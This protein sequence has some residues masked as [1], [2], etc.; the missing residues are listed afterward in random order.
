MTSSKLNNIKINATNFQGKSPPAEGVLVFG[1]YIDGAAWSLSTNSLCESLP[2]Q[3]WC[4]LPDIHFMPTLV[5]K[6]TI[7]WL[8]RY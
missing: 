7:S 4:N 1:L 3:R 2:G 6:N 5:S 8:T